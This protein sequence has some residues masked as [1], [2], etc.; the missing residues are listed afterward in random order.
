MGYLVKSPEILDL[1]QRAREEAAMELMAQGVIT[2]QPSPRQQL[3]Y[4]DAVR[5][6]A[7]LDAKERAYYE[8]LP[9]QIA[10]ENQKIMADL[11]AGKLYLAND[12]GDGARVIHFASCPS[13]RH[14]I[15]RDISHELEIQL[16]G[17]IHGSWH[18]GPGHDFVAKWPDLMTL[19]QV[20]QLRSY[21]AC[22]RCNPDTKERRK[23]AAL[24]PKP[25][26]IT[27][28]TPERIGR[29]YETTAGEYLGVLESYTVGRDIIVLHCSER[30]YRGTR[31]SL[32]IMLPKQAVS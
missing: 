4:D 29:E 10:A 26:K 15:D 30:D 3:A 17:E 24:N 28:I 16:A 12:T 8:Q 22:Q 19:E 27:S 2:F 5:F 31:E 11:N 1:E 7:E 25:S 9:A 14:Q 13:V 18:A 21:R 32:V 20:E 6:A 23:R